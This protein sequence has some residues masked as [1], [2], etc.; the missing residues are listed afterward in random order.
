MTFWLVREPGKSPPHARV[1]VAALFLVAKKKNKVAS[2]KKL[3]PVLK[4]L[5][6]PTVMF[7]EPYNSP[8]RNGPPKTPKSEHFW[9]FLAQI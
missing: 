7:L 2:S 6:N 9:V 1:G 8:F 5:G 4:N 3:K